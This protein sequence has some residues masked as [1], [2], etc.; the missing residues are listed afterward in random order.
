MEYNA[1]SAHT[2]RQSMILTLNLKRDEFTYR[3]TKSYEERKQQQ[4]QQ[5]NGHTLYF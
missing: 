5:Q 2:D 1:C 4:Q 3:S